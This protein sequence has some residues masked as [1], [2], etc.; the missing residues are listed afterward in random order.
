MEALSDANFKFNNQSLQKHQK[1]K[2]MQ[3]K[4]IEAYARA[5]RRIGE[6]FDYQIDCLL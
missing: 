5:I 6:F 3:P 2:G 1:L 4:I